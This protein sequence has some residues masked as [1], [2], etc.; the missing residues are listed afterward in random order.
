MY[1]QD[2]IKL[3]AE[4]GGAPVLEILLGQKLFE[5]DKDEREEGVDNA[6]KAAAEH[7]NNDIVGL[8]LKKF[9]EETKAH[10][11][12]GIFRAMK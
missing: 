7:S 5:T 8:L 6:L 9:P 3:A 1:V 2:L 4:Q 12:A 10:C 11:K